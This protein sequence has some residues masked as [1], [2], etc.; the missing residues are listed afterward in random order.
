MQMSNKSQGMTS[1]VPQSH[2]LQVGT[3]VKYKNIDTPGAYINEQTGELWRFTQDSIK[4]GCS[5]RLWIETKAMFVKIDNNPFVS[6]TS[7]ALY[8]GSKNISHAIPAE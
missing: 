5:P 8:C 4:P 6:N 3:R 7:A 1:H 2:G